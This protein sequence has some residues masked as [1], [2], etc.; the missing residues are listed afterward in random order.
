MLN[1]AA[2]L[3]HVNTHTQI[4]TQHNATLSHTL[5]LTPFI[6]LSGKGLFTNGQ[7][8][9]TDAMTWYDHDG[10]EVLRTRCCVSPE[11]TTY[12]AKR[13]AVH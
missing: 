2:L 10:D 9:R 8:T 3:L 5:S 4:A 1:L 13:D 11:R 12:V 6:E 7:L